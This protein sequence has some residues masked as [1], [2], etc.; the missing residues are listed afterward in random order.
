M[1]INGFLGVSLID[2]PEKISSVIYTS[3]CN[4]RCPFCH[5]PDLIPANKGTMDEADVL[6]DIYDRREFI[7][8][9]T[10]TGG[11]P[12]LQEQL[13]PFLEKIKNM[14]LLVKIDTNGY[15]PE[16]LGEMIKNR[17]VDY[18]AMDIKSSFEKYSKATGI[19]IA[20]NRIFKS[21]EVIMDSRIG[22]EFRTTA[23]P[24]LVEAE[25]FH[26]IGENIEGA[27]LYVIQQ[28]ENKN[29]FDKKYL[30]ITP[31]PNRQLEEFSE[32]MQKYV[33]KVKIA[34][35]AAVA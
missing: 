23:V 11:E 17:L 15:M 7:D 4:F 12:L 28:F 9:I 14:G 27:F 32:I 5:N 2:Y 33:R 6:D 35:T 8:G 34:N 30:D 13:V 25:D 22:Y 20:V 31:Y 19:E 24:G 29:T 18:V 16:K 26:K 3:P 1:R 10:L 21:I